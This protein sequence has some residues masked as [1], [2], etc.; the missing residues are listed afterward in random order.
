MS[1]GKEFKESVQAKAQWIATRRNQQVKASHE[2]CVP[3]GRCIAA[4]GGR[5]DPASTTSAK[6]GAEGRDPGSLR[7]LRQDGHE[8]PP[9][10]PSRACPLAMTCA[11]PPLRPVT[12]T[13]PKGDGR[14]PRGVQ[15]VSNHRGVPMRPS[16]STQAACCL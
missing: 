9:P 5:V 13:S 14:E 10:R 16:R 3:K 7:P 6:T 2:G 11:H 8:V 15:A 1:T 12:G 4:R